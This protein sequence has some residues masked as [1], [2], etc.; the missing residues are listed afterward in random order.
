MSGFLPEL[1]EAGEGIGAMRSMMITVGRT[2]NCAL[3][4]DL[5]QHSPLGSGFDTVV[6][7]AGG[8]ACQRLIS[9]PLVIS[10]CGCHSVSRPFFGSRVSGITAATWRS[11]LAEEQD[12]GTPGCLVVKRPVGCVDRP[13][14][15]LW[16]FPPPE[17]GLGTNYRMPCSL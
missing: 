17:R 9:A 2:P 10:N 5:T 16:V 14:M 12:R 6:P 11:R 4:R 1:V 8:R 13:V 3:Q 15:R 7:G